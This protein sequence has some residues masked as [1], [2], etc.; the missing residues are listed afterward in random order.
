MDLNYNFDYLR[1]DKN[2]TQN[3]CVWCITF[4]RYFHLLIAD[5]PSVCSLILW[6]KLLYLGW[7]SKTYVHLL[8]VV[9][10]LFTS[11]LR[12]P[13]STTP[14][15]LSF[16][17]SQGSVRIHII[18]K[19]YLLAFQLPLAQCTVCKFDEMNFLLSTWIEFT[20][21]TFLLNLVRKDQHP[22]FASQHLLL[23]VVSWAVAVQS[24]VSLFPLLQFVGHRGWFCVNGH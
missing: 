13:L 12:P 22:L 5:G 1:E 10:T 11:T 3:I 17:L 2:S 20:F 7:I 15:S 14:V 21:S 4:S 8:L 23:V 6:S 16:L 18:Y 24:L 19:I 9:L